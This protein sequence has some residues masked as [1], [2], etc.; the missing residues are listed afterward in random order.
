MH[1]SERLRDLHNAGFVHRDVKPGNIMFLL[2]R[3]VWTL[4]DFGCATR[5]GTDAAVS[6][7]L[8]Y[9]APE[10]LQDLVDGRKATHVTPAVD[11]WAL[12]IVA[13]ELFLGKPLFEQ[14]GV[15]PVEDVRSCF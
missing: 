11:A 2:R 4:I 14:S 5:A 6:F 12:G 8:H 13:L 1:V 9:A 3:K 15:Q 10:V 7:S